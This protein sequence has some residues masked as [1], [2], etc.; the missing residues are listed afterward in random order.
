MNAKHQ[1]KRARY[2]PPPLD[3]S[4][5][6][7]DLSRNETWPVGGA[8][9][10]S[11]FRF[12]ASMVA[13]YPDAGPL[14]QAIAD[15]HHVA[16]EQVVVTAGGDEAIDRTIR[17]CMRDRAAEFRK[18]LTHH[19]TFEMFDVYAN[20]SAGQLVG[21]TWLEGDFPLPEYL[22]Q[23][24]QSVAL[25]ALV[26]PNN[27]TGRAIPTDIL[28]QAVGELEGAGIP[29]LVD[30]AYI[31]FAADDPTEWLLNQSRAVMIRSFSK[32]FGMAGLRL[33]YALCADVEMAQAIRSIGGP[34]PASQI[35]LVLGQRALQATPQ[36]AEETSRIL[37]HRERLVQWL[38]E[39]QFYVFPTD[40]NF[41]L[42]RSPQAM[43]LAKRLLDQGIA[44]R[45]FPDKPLLE[46]C[47]RITVPRNPAEMQ[48]FARAIGRESSRPPL[49]EG[50]V[51]EPREARPGSRRGQVERQTRETTIECRVNLDQP[52]PP[53]IDTGLGFFDHMLTALAVHGQFDLQLVCHGDLHVDDHHSIEDCGLVIGAA[54]DQA[55]GDRAGVGRYGW[56]LLPM[57][58]ALAEV[59][60]D[61]SGRPASA[62]ELGLGGERIGEVATENLTHFFQSFATALRAALHVHVLKGDNDHHRAEAA[63]KGVAKVL[64]QAV[65]PTGSSQIPSTKGTL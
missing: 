49:V 54:I 47:L 59:A 7:A 57:D 26:S 31:E 40:A 22:G 48:L 61:L 33:G 9:A 14:Q 55:L 17:V 5:I 62:I 32:A 10:L 56:C 2:E 39:L 21:P 36:L 6:R 24:E 11:T 23:A 3:R 25:A 27:P 12:D 58:E 30:L 50:S 37:Q 15:R 18:I 8:A 34:Y 13:Q 43:P 51:L 38:E 35:S 53:Q 20:S 64:G 4:K 52:Q 42:A 28:R 65:A 1:D 63:F 29:V 60:I 19:P 41:L 46:N 45:W 44:V 16:P